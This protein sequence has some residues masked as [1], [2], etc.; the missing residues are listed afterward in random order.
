M[1]DEYAEINIED[2]IAD[3]E[4]RYRANLNIDD[5]VDSIRQDG[6]LIPIV[7]RRQDDKFQLIS[8]FR[9]I[10]A[11]TK[12]GRKK[13]QAKILYG[14][15]DVEARRISLLEN[16]ERNSLTSWD[17]VAAAE[18][19]REQG[20]ENAEIAEAFRVSV[21]TIQR[22]LRVAEAPDDFRRALERDD[23]T[24]Q[25]AYEA[26]KR[27]VPVS[28][29][30]KHGRSVRYLRGLSHKS[31]KKDNV[32]IQR[33]ADGEILINIRYRPGKSDLSR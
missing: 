20:M 7:V 10:A 13:V 18:R 19:F 28:D 4:F 30:L 8:G 23:I 26:L 25:Q 15:S 14:I 11:L 9:R 24:I 29:L 3:C 6:Q 12:L 22:Y 21:R 5:L 1:Q 16:L 31:E 2:L 32:R 27:H 33:K 17:Q